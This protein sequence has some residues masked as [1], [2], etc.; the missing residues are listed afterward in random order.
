MNAYSTLRRREV[1]VYRQYRQHLRG[2]QVHHLARHHYHHHPPPC[3]ILRSDKLIAYD[4]GRKT[5]AYY[6]S[7]H[8]SIYARVRCTN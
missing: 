4:T 6:E 2:G 7:F 8:R 1:G 3:H 5:G